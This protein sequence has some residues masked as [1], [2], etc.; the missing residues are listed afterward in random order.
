MCKT[1]FWVG[2]SMVVVGQC[3]EKN[4]V[5]TTRTITVN[6]NTTDPFNDYC[7]DCL[8]TTSPIGNLIIEKN[9]SVSGPVVW[10]NFQFC[11]DT[12]NSCGLNPPQGQGNGTGTLTIRDLTLKTE[13]IDGYAIYSMDIQTYLS[14]LII[15]GYSAAP[16]NK[17]G[18]MR[19]QNADYCSDDTV[20]SSDHPTINRVHVKN[21]CRGI[22]IQ[23]SSCSYVKDST[24][25]NNTDNGFYYAAGSY[26]SADG[27]TH[28]T[29]DN[30]VATDSGQ[31]GF[32]LIGGFNHT[33]KNCII[34]GTGGAG[35]TVWN[36]N[37]SNYVSN[38]I[39][40]NVNSN[41]TVSGHGG[42]IDHLKGASLAQHVELTDTNALLYVSGCTFNGGGILSGPY[43]S[44]VIYNAC[45]G[46][47]TFSTE[48]VSTYLP[49][50]YSSIQYNKTDDGRTP[51][52]WHNMKG[53]VDGTPS[54]T[55][56][57]S[58][59][60]GPIIGIA[61][62]STVVFIGLIYIFAFIL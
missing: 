53:L 18:A 23:D 28:S 57:D 41:K 1:M 14:D 13:T 8:S 35:L 4:D 47:M 55:D 43:E 39:F 48:D 62:A 46:N 26:T 34:D 61:T 16:E 40:T 12:I 50:E 5:G 2:L 31:H 11:Y 38:V 19:I 51:C 37:G 32:L 7:P 9:S 59:G 49:A 25:T 36:T 45:P 54:D 44:V 15:D 20:P 27:N 24:S 60:V 58:L 22:R 56:D 17:G 30:C 6:C 3:V 10:T 29:F 42:S 21:G 33:V 52:P